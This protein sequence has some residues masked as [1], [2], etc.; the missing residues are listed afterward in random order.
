M[1]THT[2]SSGQ[3]ISTPP[4]FVG[5][6]PNCSNGTTTTDSVPAGP[7]GPS[8][9]GVRPGQLKPRGRRSHLCWLAVPPALLLA[10]WLLL[11]RTPLLRRQRP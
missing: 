3:T 1:E 5:T 11:R 4:V 2:G 9:P 7:Q 10:V 6:Y 8:G